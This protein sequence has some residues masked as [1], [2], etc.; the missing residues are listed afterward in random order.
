MGRRTPLL[1]MRGDSPCLWMALVAVHRALVKHRRHSGRSLVSHYGG[2]R[3]SPDVA[4]DRIVKRESQVR[5]QL[6]TCFATTHTQAVGAESVMDLNATK[7]LCELSRRL[8]HRVCCAFNG[9]WLNQTEVRNHKRSS[10][11]VG[12]GTKEDYTVRPVVSDCENTAAIPRTTS[13]VN[14]RPAFS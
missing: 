7:D 6:R 11:P 9:Y 8:I 12:H 5:R 13:A 3:D 14:R 4:G 1:M 2:N 10:E